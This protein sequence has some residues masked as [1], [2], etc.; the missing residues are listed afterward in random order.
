[1]RVS[2]ISCA[3]GVVFVSAIA[4][5]HGSGFGTFT[6]EMN[7]TN[8]SDFLKDMFQ[9]LYAVPT[10]FLLTLAAFGVLATLN[11]RMRRP[12]CSILCPA[13]VAT[14]ALA[15]VLG[16]WVPLVIMTLG[17]SLFAV[18]ALTSNPA[19]AESGVTQD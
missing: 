15:L 17:G 1:M 16:E 14:G 7:E 10:V 12:V 2:S 4:M 3:L 5:L 8:A 13:V 19:D 18:A 9:V 11:R 6:A